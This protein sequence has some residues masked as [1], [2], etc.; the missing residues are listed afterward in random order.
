MS[1]SCEL[2]WLIAPWQR[3][4]TLECM[5]VYP[6]RALPYTFSCCLET[7]RLSS[8]FSRTFT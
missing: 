3:S 2:G 7:F 1:T 5:P 6:D 8:V 4:F